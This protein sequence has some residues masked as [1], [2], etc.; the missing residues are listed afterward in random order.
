[1]WLKIDKL[2]INL[3]EVALIETE[4]M[5]VMFCFKNGETKTIYRNSPE[6][7]QGLFDFVAENLKKYEV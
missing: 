2:M 6:A 1:M 7:A 3:S 4:D 5:R